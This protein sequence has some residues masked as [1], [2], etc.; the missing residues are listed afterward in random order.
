MNKEI[1]KKGFYLFE[2][3]CIELLKF[4][5]YEILKCN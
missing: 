1:E 2:F 5:Y 4:K 3:K